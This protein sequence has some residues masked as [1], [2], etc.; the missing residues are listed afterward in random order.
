MNRENAYECLYL[1][2]ESQLRPLIAKIEAS[3]ECALDDVYQIIAQMFDAFAHVADEGKSDDEER[4]T[5]YLTK[6]INLRDEAFIK[7]YRDLIY[8][9]DNRATRCLQGHTQNETRIVACEFPSKLNDAKA[10]IRLANK[11][12]D[13]NVESYRKAY[14]KYAEIESLLDSLPQYE[15]TSRNL[16]R[17]RKWAFWVYQI[18]IPVIL[19]VF[20]YIFSKN[21]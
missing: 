16:K 2:Y 19:A 20:L 12:E 13:Q 1:E 21:R 3:R 5:D 6:A 18:L 8:I 10:Y 15:A 11:E 17:T 14:E 9:I 4:V 7:C